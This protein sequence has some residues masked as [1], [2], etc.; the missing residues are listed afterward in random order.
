MDNSVILKRLKIIQDLTEELNVLKEQ[1]T[2]ALD[3]DVEYQEMQEKTKQI[4]DEAKIEKDK[5]VSR[6]TYKGL[7][8]Q[9]KEK[10]SEIKEHREILAQE[11]AD[12]YK[13]TGVLE[14]VD[15]KGNTKKI[16]FSATLIS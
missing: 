13:E 4:R 11:L 5:I 1:Y 12:Y 14:I 15:N 8:D 10:R 3:N 6:P 2:D 16:K 9:V 7:S